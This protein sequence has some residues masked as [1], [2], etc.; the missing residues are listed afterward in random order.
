MGQR[1]RLF[2]FSLKTGVLD[3]SGK[4]ALVTFSGELN[5]ICTEFSLHA[6]LEE[7]FIH[8]LLSNQ[9][10]G[11]AKKLELA[12][13]EM[14]E[15]LDD[16]VI[17]AENLKLSNVRSGKYADICLEFY[18]AWNRFI[19][20]YHVHINEE[21]EMVQ[22][23]LRALCTEEELSNAFATI[24]GSMS[25]PEL[26]GMLRMMIIAMNPDER[27]GLLSGI[28]AHAS[29]QAF[30]NISNLARDVLSAEDWKDLKG[31]LGIM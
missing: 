7:K 28:K 21:E 20:F 17:S 25:P 8:P 15:Q 5:A 2:Q 1:A 10:P 6:S 9:V 26:M 27:A 24:V 29:L 12:H 30:Q 14:H 23:T 18:R 3:Y 4:V 31:R 22:P 13:H 16:L 11:G 19:V